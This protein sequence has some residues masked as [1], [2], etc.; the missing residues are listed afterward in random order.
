M[1]CSSGFLK[2]IKN[3]I[4]E[5]KLIALK[6]QPPF[7]VTSAR[8]VCCVRLMILMAG[9]WMFQ[10]HRPR[11][12]V[13][14]RAEGEKIEPCS[15]P[16]GSRE[17]GRMQKW[18]FCQQRRWT[19]RLTLLSLVL[20]LFFLPFF[21]ASFFFLHLLF[22]SFL[23]FIK[24]NC[25]AKSIGAKRL[26]ELDKALASRPSWRSFVWWE[27]TDPRQGTWHGPGVTLCIWQL[28][29]GPKHAVGPS[30]ISGPWQALYP[31]RRCWVQACC[32][33]SIVLDGDGAPVQE[34]CALSKASAWSLWKKFRIKILLNASNV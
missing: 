3:G 24:A 32:R 31:L 23:L 28:S 7:L 21:P 14:F 16:K 30:I 34:S 20:L 1:K 17:E 26:V 25:A 15:L 2:D 11:R 22:F 4:P 29:H 18:C 13:K 12:R 19:I 27:Y 33:S 9:T 8:W 5:V 6:L 10:P